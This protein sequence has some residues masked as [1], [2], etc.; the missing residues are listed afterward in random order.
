LSSSFVA[1]SVFKRSSAHL[2]LAVAAT[3]R[4]PDPAVA[5][6]RGQR[7]ADAV[8]RL[9][10][11]WRPLAERQ[12]ARTLA[13]ADPRA[14]IRANYQHYGKL[15]TELANAETWCGT[16]ATR[17]HLADG[18]HMAALQDGG[19]LV[20]GH[21]GNWELLGRGHCQAFGSADVLVKPVHNPTLDRWINGLRRQFGLTPLY[22]RG[23]AL[24]LYRRLRDG[25]PVIMLGDQNSLRH[26]GMFVE[27]FGHPACAH[28]GPVMLAL[29]AGRPI[30]TAFG[31]RNPDNSVTIRYEPPIAVPRGTLREQ[32]F[33]VVQAIAQRTEAAI[34]RHPAQW[35]WVHRRW[36]NQPDASVPAWQN[37]RALT[38][39]QIV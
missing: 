24:E 12:I 1:D 11:R 4:H 16:H 6:R 36:L 25:R 23:R 3:L 30:L 7:L 32:T 10:R 26:E 31:H 28:Y 37:P 19:L 21:M 34:R 2:L 17:F 38:P 14:T 22:T 20:T 33:A 29:R 8:W 35:F 13:P 27:F 18:R 9:D 15:L 39:S 5:Y